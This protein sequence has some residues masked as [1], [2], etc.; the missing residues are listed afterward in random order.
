MALVLGLLKL[1]SIVSTKEELEDLCVG[2][3]E[4]LQVLR[5]TF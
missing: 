1:T 5:K 3:R 2:M 4:C